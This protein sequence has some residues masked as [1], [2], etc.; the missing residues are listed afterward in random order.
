MIT[1]ID[2]DDAVVP[3]ED[4]YLAFTRWCRDHRIATVPDRKVFATLLKNKFAITE[5]TVAGVSCWIN[6]RLR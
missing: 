6:I 3:K 2:A 1:R 5:K 4:M